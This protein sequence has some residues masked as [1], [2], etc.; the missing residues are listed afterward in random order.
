MI[1]DAMAILDLKNLCQSFFTWGE[2]DSVH[3]HANNANTSIHT[4]MSVQSTTNVMTISPLDQ[5][6]YMKYL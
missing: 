3:P 2:R 4:M 6:A 5:K 1:A